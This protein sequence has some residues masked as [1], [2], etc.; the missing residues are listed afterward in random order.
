[1]KDIELNKFINKYDYITNTFFNRY[2][3]DKRQID[4][5]ILNYK[6]KIFLALSN[7]NYHLKLFYDMDMNVIYEDKTISIYLDRYQIKNGNF[8]IIADYKNFDKQDVLVLKNI[9]KN[10]ELYKFVIKG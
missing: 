1:M 6:S 7:K 8:K 10:L 3:T 2:L 5:V 9:Y 4:N